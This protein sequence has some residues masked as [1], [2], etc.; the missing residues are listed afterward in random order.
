[1]CGNHLLC[2]DHL[3]CAPHCTAVLAAAELTTTSLAFC[4][5]FI[6]AC[7]CATP[8]P[9]PTACECSV[10][11]PGQGQEEA[12]NFTWGNAEMAS[13]HLTCP[14]T[15]APVPEPRPTKRLTA[16]LPCATRHS[17]RRVPE[18]GTGALSSVLTTWAVL[19]RKYEINIKRRIRVSS[20]SNTHIHTKSTPW[21]LPKPGL[22]LVLAGSTGEHRVTWPGPPAGGAA[23]RHGARQTTRE[24]RAAA[25][26]SWGR[27]CG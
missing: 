5:P 15:T 6:A 19:S 8:S 10:C 4:R 14:W 27:T 2:G 9:Q 3:C 24:A 13:R 21:Y 25:E 12:R 16:E 23:G 11:C 18:G 17:A 26:S 1:M 20:E 22:G 7:P